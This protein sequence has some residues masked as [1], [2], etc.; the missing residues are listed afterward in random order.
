M[1]FYQS[2]RGALLKDGERD[3]LFPVTV[4][5]DIQLDYARHHNFPDVSYRDTCERFRELEDYAWLY[6]TEI[7]CDIKPGERAF[8][9]TEGIE[10]EYDVILNGE[11]LLHHEG[12]FT[13]VEADITDALKKGNSLEIYIYPH[14]KRAGAPEDRAQADQCCKPAV[15]YGWDWHPRLLVSGLW[16]E[17]YIETRNAETIRS[18][19]CRYRLSDDLKEAYV[20]FDIDC[21]AETVTEFYDADG[22]AVYVGK[23]AAFTLKDIKLWWCNGQGEQYLYTYKVKSAS[24]EKTGRVGFKRIA[25][26]M[27]GPNA[28]ANPK[29]FPKT[30]SNPPLTVCLNGRQIFAKGSNFVNPEI[31]TGEITRKTYE[32]LVKAAKEANMNIFRCWG[33]AI[34]DKEPFFDL[35]DEM[36]IMVWQEFP[37]AC[38]NYIGTDRY[39]S[40]LEPEATAII[41]RLRTHVSL[42]LW[43]GGNE[44]FNSWSGMTDQ[45]LA[46]RLLNKLCYEHSPEIPFLMTS[47]V[48]GAAHGCYIFTGEEL[49]GKSVYEAMQESSNTAYCEFGVPSITER[50]YLERVFDKEELSVLPSP[51]SILWQLHHGYG[52][53]G[54]KRWLCLDVLDKYFGRQDSLDS[55]ISL[56][57]WLQ[58]EGY[59]AIFEEARRQ[60]PECSMAINW[61]YNEPWI[62]G[63]G[64]SLLTYPANKKPAYYAVQSALRPVM[65][66]ARIKKFDYVGSEELSAEIWLLND[67]PEAVSDTVKVYLTVDG[68][69]EFI[70]EW[71]TGTVNANTNKKGHSVCVRLPVTETQKFTLT[72]EAECGSSSYDLLLK[73]PGERV[74]TRQLN[75]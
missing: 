39:L 38:N 49:D 4:P 54:D 9:V 21:D 62:T 60:K 41:K 1:K 58:C 61:C 6:K 59:K 52:A 70:M 42:S 7:C 71:A 67:S 13:R 19:C 40:V 34:I 22:N 23:E 51:D 73:K 2:F 28:W 57:H 15:G 33:G 36:G 56:S 45:S 14:P 53:W 29:T 48:M 75:L 30:R 26:E 20:T 32:P 35:C 74:Y 24:D 46:L 66:S 18:A 5:G 50:K 16:N 31:F 44:L 17:T 43:C 11:R 12:M 10:Y 47:P 37:L 65:P 55:Y 25:L 68:K 72:L 63:A 8:F 27:N 64:N 69:K 3:D